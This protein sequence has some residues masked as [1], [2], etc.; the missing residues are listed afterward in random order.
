MR[1]SVLDR[2]QPETR[3]EER[4]GHDGGTLH[5]GSVAAS[6]LSR[7]HPHHLLMNKEQVLNHSL[8]L[9]L[10]FILS[11]SLSLFPPLSVCLLDISCHRPPYTH[12]LWKRNPHALSLS[13]SLSLPLPISLFWHQCWVTKLHILNLWLLKS[14]PSLPLSLPDTRLLTYTRLLSMWRHVW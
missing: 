7:H 9:S 10:S 13:L 11:L 3:R 14:I 12:T 5:A 8:S 1:G 4:R 6:L 2:K